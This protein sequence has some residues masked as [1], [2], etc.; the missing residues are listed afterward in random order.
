MRQKLKLKIGSKVEF[1]SELYE[2]FQL[3]G[4]SIIANVSADKVNAVM[5]HFIAMHEEP[6]FFILELPTNQNDE[7][8][9]AP[10]VIETFHK[11]IYYIDG[12]SQAEALA[13]MSRVGNLL[14]HDGLSAFG[15]GCHES[16]DEIMFGK[17]NVLTIFSKHIKQYHDFFEK[18]DIEKTEHLIT[19]WDTFSDD[20]P[21]ISETYESNGKRVYDIPE[22]FKEWGIYFAER[23]EA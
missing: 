18:H 8:E 13:I 3:E 1:D 22:Q 19:A 23:R 14:L 4:N 20:H 7:T 10:G 9:T 6:L 5:R 15:Y 17:Y 12:C 2:G 16:G 11:D 21:G